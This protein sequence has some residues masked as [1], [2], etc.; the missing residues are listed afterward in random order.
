MGNLI[1]CKNGVLIFWCRS[2]GVYP[3]FRL[4]LSAVSVVL[5]N[6][7]EVFFGGNLNIY[8]NW[9][10]RFSRRATGLGDNACFVSEDTAAFSARNFKFRAESFQLVVRFSGFR[11]VL[12]GNM[13][14]YFLLEMQ[15]STIIVF[16][17]LYYTI[18][19]QDILIN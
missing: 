19:L 15:L 16:I 12:S 7:V 18:C 14:T 9:V 11:V 13:K 6:K 17:F 10:L 8:K 1:I 4:R 2:I 5:G 3:V